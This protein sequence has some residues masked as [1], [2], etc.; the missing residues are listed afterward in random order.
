MATYTCFTR[1]WWRWEYKNGKKEKVPDGGA[2]RTVQAVFT[3]TDALEKAR[4]YCEQWNNSHNP[5][6]LSR[7]CEFTSNF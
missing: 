2:R 6:P 3:G 1:N 5:G 4:A 7:K